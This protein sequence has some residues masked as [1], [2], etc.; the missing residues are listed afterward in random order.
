[1][2]G[3]FSIFCSSSSSETLKKISKKAGKK[4]SHRGPDYSGT[5]DGKGFVLQHERLAIID[6]TSGNQPFE[7]DDY[8][9]TVNGE[10]YNWWDL[11]DE[12]YHYKTKSD[13]EIILSCYKKYGKDTF[14]KL[15]GIFAFV[16]YDKKNKEFI[17]ARD[18]IGVVPLYIGY[19]S[20]GSIVVSSELKAMDTAMRIQIFPPGHYYSSHEN[21]T[22]TFSLFQTLVQPNME[23]YFHER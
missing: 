18:A 12:T 11:K 20:D 23:L 15:D 8:I 7:N 3:I 5:I 1:M 10:I 14:S 4:L 22:D 9:L 2:C 6:P 16:L 17:V 21:G 19:G 13:C